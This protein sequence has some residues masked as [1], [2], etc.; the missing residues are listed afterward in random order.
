VSPRDRIFAAV[1]VTLLFALIIVM[2]T[3]SGMEAL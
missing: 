1:L 3:W 2:T